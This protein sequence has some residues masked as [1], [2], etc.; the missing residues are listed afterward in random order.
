MT[1]PYGPKRNSKQPLIEAAATV[2]EA[3]LKKLQHCIWLNKQIRD[4]I[5]SIEVQWGIAITQIEN[6]PRRTYKLTEVELD[7]FRQMVA[8]YRS[9]C[10]AVPAISGHI[11]WELGSLLY[12]LDEAIPELYQQYQQALE[13]YRASAEGWTDKSSATSRKLDSVLKK[14]EERFEETEREKG[15]NF[16]LGLRLLG[17]ERAAELLRYMQLKRNIVYVNL[18]AEATVTNGISR[19]YAVALP[20]G[21]SYTGSTLD[22]AIPLLGA[23]KQLRVATVD[24]QDN[25]RKYTRLRVQVSADTRYLE[26]MNPKLHFVKATRFDLIFDQPFEGK[27]VQCSFLP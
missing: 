6:I 11:E 15:M 3:Y 23:G 10:E 22:A 27:I 1:Q 18:Q 9:V 19:V 13:A 16:R 7:Y 14:V 24:I 2:Y 8:I 20:A 5:A 26:G 25:K 12:D 21:I 4:I 17:E